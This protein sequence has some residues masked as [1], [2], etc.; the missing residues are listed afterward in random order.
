MKNKLFLYTMLVV[1]SSIMYSSCTKVQSLVKAATI[2]WSGV[3][4]TFEVPVVTDVSATTAIGTGSFTYNLDSMIKAQTANQLGLA[5]IDEFMLSSCVLTIDPADVDAANNFANFESADAT[6]STNINSTPA[7]I[8]S[9]T[10]NPDTYAETLNIPVDKT[11]NLKSF[12][13]PLG[14]TTFNYIVHAKGR[15]VTT[16]VLHVTAEIGYTI[17]VTP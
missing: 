13:S 12:I 1:C 16:K 3:N 7:T 17:H 15:R 8:G 4:V 9:V 5:N 11:T 10:N 14:N 2:S 6:L